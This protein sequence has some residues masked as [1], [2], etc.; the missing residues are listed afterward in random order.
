M[1]MFELNGIL[2]VKMS[3]P[4]A[5]LTNAYTDKHIWLSRFF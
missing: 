4:E 5:H 1:L 2:F 3:C